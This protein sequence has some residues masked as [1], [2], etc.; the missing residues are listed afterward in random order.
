MTCMASFSGA[1]QLPAGKPF[2]GRNKRA[3]QVP[4]ALVRE[5]VDRLATGVRLNP[6]M[7]LGP[8]C[9][10]PIIGGVRGRK[11]AGYDPVYEIDY[12]RLTLRPASGSSI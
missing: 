4:A 1:N 3:C 2:R 6:F 11:A 8:A 7:E 5:A 10:A 12:L 9:V